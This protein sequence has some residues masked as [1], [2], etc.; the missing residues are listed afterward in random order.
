MGSVK[1]AGVARLEKKR[2]VV[3]LVILARPRIRVLSLLRGGIG[4][5][6]PLLRFSQ[7]S[8]SRDMAGWLGA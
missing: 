6:S 3:R 8:K 4:H 1:G 2:I 5:G 7:G